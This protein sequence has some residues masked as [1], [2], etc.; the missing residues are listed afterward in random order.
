MPPIVERKVDG[1]LVGLSKAP[2]VDMYE[3]RCVLKDPEAGES[4]SFHHELDSFQLPVN[5]K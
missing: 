5:L 4:E 3:P 2:S 1:S